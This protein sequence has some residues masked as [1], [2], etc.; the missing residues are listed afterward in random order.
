[1]EVRRFVGEGGVDGRCVILGVA[2]AA[3]CRR[4]LVVVV[5]RAH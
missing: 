2:T 5:G 4:S 3:G 1:M